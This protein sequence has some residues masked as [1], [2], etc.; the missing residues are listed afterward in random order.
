V[1]ELKEDI[2]EEIKLYEPPTLS[3]MVKK[4]LMIEQKNRAIWKVWQNV[5]SNSI[6]KVNT[7]YRDPS[8]TKTVTYGM[9]QK[10]GG[11]SNG[12]SNSFTSSTSVNTLENSNRPKG[13]QRLT[14]AE[15]QEKRKKEE[16]FRYDEK[17]STSHV[18]RN[19]QLR[20]MLVT[21]EH[22]VEDSEKEPEPKIGETPQLSMNSIVGFT[23]RRS[24]KIWGNI[25]D[26]KVK[27]L[28]DCGATHNFISKE[29]VEK[30]QLK[31][32]DTSRY[33]VEVWDGH[34]IKCKGV[35]REVPLKVQ[36]EPV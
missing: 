14:E 21:D 28:I 11:K 26:Y 27:V 34:K 12:P 23:S 9:S 35:C 18:C 19:K 7:S 15:L 30:L 32:D 5:A 1:N 16:C 4:A 8:Y 24:L 20:I 25:D 10:G 29:L 36:E 13:F 31:V 22:D 33:V 6:S 17:W 3:I 2:G